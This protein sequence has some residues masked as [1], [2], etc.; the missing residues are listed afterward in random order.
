MAALPA[1]CRHSSR[2]LRGP[3]QS[4]CQSVGV[5]SLLRARKLDRTLTSGRPAPG[6][7]VAPFA[8]ESINHGLRGGVPRGQFSEVH[9]PVSSGRHQPRLGGAGGGHDARGMGGARR[10]LRSVRSRSGRRRP[11]SSCPGCCGCGGRRCRRPAAPSTRPGCRAS[12]ACQG[13]G[14]LLERTIDRAI[15]AV[16]LVAQSGVCTM[17]VLDLID[18]PG[19]RRWRACRGP[20]GCACSAWSRAARPRCCCWPRR[21]WLAARAVCRLRRESGR[22]T[23]GVGSRDTEPERVR[24]CRHRSRWAVPKGD[25]R[26]DPTRRSAGRARTIARGGWA[27]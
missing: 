14:T 24:P 7:A 3:V 2:Q 16:N 20:R 12:A 21:P 27:G 18:A 11:A 6:D 8:L 17:V 9:G 13:P 1:P 10:H 15:K 26:R 25:S 4:C 22:V 19:R 23:P 5:V